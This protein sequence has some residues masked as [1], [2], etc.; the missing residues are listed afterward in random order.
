M[1]LVV[2]AQKIVKDLDEGLRR[3][4]EYAYPLEDARMKAAGRPGTI[5]AQIL[6][7]A[8]APPGRVQ[9]FMLEEP[10]GF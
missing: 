6:V 8:W 4:R 10:I 7:M 2:G 9:L 5:V 3:V 1:I